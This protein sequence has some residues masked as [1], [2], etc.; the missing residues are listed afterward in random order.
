MLTS[1]LGHKHGP[2]HQELKMAKFPRRK[3]QESG[4]DS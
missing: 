1:V 3:G 4:G 2:I